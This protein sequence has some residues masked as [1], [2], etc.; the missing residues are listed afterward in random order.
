MR[1]PLA[2]AAAGLALAGLAPA[3]HATCMPPQ[4]DKLTGITVTSCSP[5]GGPVTTTVCFRD[6]V[7]YSYTTGEGPGGGS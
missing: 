5:P 3:A 4:E 7:C 2:L 1:I 6:L